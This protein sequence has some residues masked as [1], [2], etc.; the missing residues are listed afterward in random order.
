MRYIVLISAA[1]DAA[2]IAAELPASYGETEAGSQA[3]KAQ[4]PSGQSWA[5]QRMADGAYLRTDGPFIE[6]KEYA[7]GP[8][9]M[10]RYE[11]PL[12]DLIGLL[13]NDHPTG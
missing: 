2:A 9:R 5:I 7:L 12:A 11:F 6:T 10:S 8:Q 3:R 13:S 1:R 4:Q